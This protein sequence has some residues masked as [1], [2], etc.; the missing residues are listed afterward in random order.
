MSR[1]FVSL[2]FLVCVSTFSIASHCRAE[3]SAVRQTIDDYVAAFN[4]GQID[5]VADYW[6]ASATHTDLE[7][8]ELTQGREAIRA[9]I[10]AGIEGQP[11]LRL[12]EEV[13][14]VRMITPQVASVKG[15]IVVTRGEQQPVESRFSAIL[16]NT[17][18]KWRIES[19]EESAVPLPPTPQAALQELNWLIGTWAEATADA[20]VTN[21]VRWSSER[22]FLVRSYAVVSEDGGSLQGT[23]LIGWDPRAAQIRSWSF[24][25][26]GSF[27]DGMWSK[28]EDSWLIRSAQ[29]LADGRAASGTYVLQ[30][31]NEDQLS[32]RLI[33]HE[34]E[35]EP[36]PSTD[37]SLL[38]RVAD[39]AEQPDSDET[40][41]AG[42]GIP[43]VSGN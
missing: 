28:N 7:T 25:S 10:E 13:E 11:G 4:A 20:T 16:V 2:V 40:S 9:D 12:R 21:D 19:I 30:K 38:V 8:G 26:D 42:D 41:A 34:I 29:T 3:E 36:Q 18:G 33:G 17:D 37:P 32:W 5:A 24:N 23:Q 31:V 35:G 27:G 1:K 39:A 6:A 15:T 43:A 14:R 22:A